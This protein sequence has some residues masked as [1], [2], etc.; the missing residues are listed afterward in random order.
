METGIIA[1]IVGFLIGLPMGYY[2]AKKRNK[3]GLHGILNVDCRD[4]NLAPG[5][6]LQLDVP[7]EDVALREQATFIVKVIT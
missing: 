4:T 2:Q 1:L 5:L 3:A 6:W 7:V